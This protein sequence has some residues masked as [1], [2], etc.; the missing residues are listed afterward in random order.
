MKNPVLHK[1]LTTSSSAKWGQP[2]ADDATPDV[3]RPGGDPE[4][5]GDDRT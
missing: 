4:A 2:A 5:L 1:G 3:L